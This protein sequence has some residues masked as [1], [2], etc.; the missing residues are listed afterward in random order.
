MAAVI[1]FGLTNKRSLRSPLQSFAEVVTATV[2]YSLASSLFLL[3]QG[4]NHS[5]I[6]NASLCESLY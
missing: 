5:I 6:P 3:W 4:P 1:K 2:L